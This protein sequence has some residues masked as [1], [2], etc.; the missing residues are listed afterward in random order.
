VNAPSTKAVPM[1]DVR[2]I[3]KAYEGR[4]RTVEAIRE[5]TCSVAGGELVREALAAVGLDEVHT[6]DPWQL[7]G[8]MQQRVAIAPTVVMEDLAI[9]L[10][11]ERDQLSTRSAPRFAELRA[12]V[13]ALVQRARQGRP[14]PQRIPRA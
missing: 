13:H 4:G 11:E 7:S 3:H 6:A 9:D 5:L 14:A 10:P 8:G 2:G 1:L 12:H